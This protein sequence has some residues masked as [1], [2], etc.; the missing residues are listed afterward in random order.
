MGLKYIEPIKSMILLLLVALSITFTFSIWTYTPSYPTIEQLPTVD[1]SVSDSKKQIGEIIKPYKMVFNFGKTLSGTTTS[2]EINDVIEE[3]KEWHISDIEMVNNN[4]DVKDFNELLRKPNRFILYFHGEVP[5]SVYSSILNVDDSA[6]YLS[7]ISFDRLVVDW[8]P[9]SIEMDIY[10]INRAN[11]KL[12]SAK[13]QAGDFRSFQRSVLAMGRE[14]AEYKE[15]TVDGSPFLVVPVGPV[16]AKRNTYFQEEISPN[17][18]R[19]ALFSDPNAVRRSQVGSNQEE[20]G[21]D[22][23][24]MRIDTEK[25]KLNY[26]YP[27]AKSEEP[28]IPSELLLSTIDFVNEHGGWTDEFRYTYMNPKTR[29]VRFR[30]FLNGLPV[31]TDVT[32]STEI[33]QRWGDNRIFSY[34][35]PYYLRGWTPPS[36]TKV[37]VLPSGIDVAERLRQSD[38]IDFSAVEEIAPGYFMKHD[39]ERSLLVME[40]SWFYLIKGNWTRFSPEQLGGERIGLE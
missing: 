37:E 7:E 15:V 5:L 38:I 39:V 13:V 28:A 26:V 40:P 33:I 30:L 23:A 34:T 31:F 16:E 9:D 27:V 11:K 18:F 32:S 22:H 6:V 12:H 14:L 36:E 25:K 20:F 8:N 1:A 35:R 3:M 29:T 17:R 2:D 24:L 4:F 19:D 10:F 21:D